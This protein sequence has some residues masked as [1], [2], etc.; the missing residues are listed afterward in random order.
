M[1]CD[2]TLTSWTVWRH[3]PCG[4]MDFVAS[5]T[6]TSWTVS[7]DRAFTKDYAKETEHH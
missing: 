6:V 4:V 7:T 1:D 5:W 3:G 2:E